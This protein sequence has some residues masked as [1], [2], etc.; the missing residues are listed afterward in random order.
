MF[1]IFVIVSVVLFWLFKLVPGDTARMMVNGLELTLSPEAYEQAYQNAR[2]SLG[3][4]QSIA[5]QYVKWFARMMTGDFGISSQYRIPVSELIAEPLKNTLMLNI[6]SVIIVML[7]TIPL[8]IHSA[9]KK[10]SVSDS[11][12]QVSS[13]VGYSLP[14]FTIALIVV[15]V[16]AIKLGWFPLNG[17]ATVG[18][19][20]EGFSGFLDRLYHMILPM[21]VIVLGSLG[22]ITRYVRATMI[23]VLKQDYIRTARAKGV[24]ERVVIYKH[25]FRNALIPMVTILTGW[26]I[27]IFSGSVIIETMFMWNGIGKVLYDGLMQ[28][29]FAVVLTMQMFYVLLALVGNLIMDIAYGLVDPRVKIAK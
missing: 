24:K 3:L 16:F 5:V 11:V 12:I 25:A 28:R 26:I 19:E 18:V 17:M 2:A 6:P 8:G 23:E 1:F 9:V 14:S 27:S 21:S 15:Y 20:Q 10:G 22:T 4:D 13:V 7:I 29:D